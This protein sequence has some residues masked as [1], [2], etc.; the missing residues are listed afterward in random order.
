MIRPNEI[1][2]YDPKHVESL[3]EATKWLIA[4]TAPI[5]ETSYSEDIEEAYSNARKLVGM[6]TEDTALNYASNAIRRDI[7]RQVLGLTVVQPATEWTEP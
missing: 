3:I 4:R 7:D 2:Q 1:G 6:Y 5:C